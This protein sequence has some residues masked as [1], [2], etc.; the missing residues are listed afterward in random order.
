MKAAIWYGPQDLRIEDIETPTA[1]AGEI[2]VKVGAAT[3]CGSDF[4]AYRFGHPVLAPFAKCPFGHE[5]A[6]TV[7]EV[8]PGV[9]NVAPGDRVVAAN[10]APCGECFFCMRQQPDLCEHPVYCKGAFAEF[11]RIPASIVRL[12]C[13]KI[14]DD[15]PF[16]TA[17]VAEPLSCV[18]NALD[19]ITPERGE[20]VAIIGAGSAGRMFEQLLSRRECEVAMVTRDPSTLE[21]ARHLN[22]GRGPDIVIEAVGKSETW[23]AAVSL[24]RKGGKVCLFGGCARGSR[25]SLDTYKLHYE[26]LTLYGVFH[27]TPTSFREAVSMLERRIVDAGPLLAG[28]RPLAAL[29]QIL[30]EGLVKKPLKIAIVP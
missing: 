7:V 12:K 1:G 9:V 26:K 22:G 4:K 11:V 5:M 19:R 14:R 24:V 3:T 29:P 13:H 21:A 27:H 23:E 30:R 16:I 6:G 8:G 28:Q 17:A 25:V 2:V 10:S 15:L 18:V 20:R